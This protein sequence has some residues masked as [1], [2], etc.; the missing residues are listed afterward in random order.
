[1]DMVGLDAS[2]SVQ[3]QHS[4][5]KDSFGR[6]M[7]DCPAMNQNFR[8]HYG[9]LKRLARMLIGKNVTKQALLYQF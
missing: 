8:Q 5:F 4:K 7:R 2:F 6:L 3:Q 1:M 9:D